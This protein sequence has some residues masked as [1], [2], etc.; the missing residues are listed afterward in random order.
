MAFFDL[1]LE[2]LQTYCSPDAEPADFDAFWRQTLDET[3]RIAVGAEYVRLEDRIY[4]LVDVY[5]VTFRGFGGQAIKGWFLEPAGNDRR[6]PC[7]VTFIGYGGGRSLP[8][9]HLAPVMSGFAHFVVDTRGQGSEWSAGDTADDAG[10]GPHLPG[11]MTRGIESPQTY[12][13]RRL[14]T[15][16]VRAV[17]AAAA[18]RHVDPTRIAVTGSSQGGGLAIAAAGLAGTTVKL[19][20]AD[21]PFLCHFRRAVTMVDTLPYAEIARYLRCHRGRSEQVFRTLDYFDAVN[22]A[23]RVSARSLLSVGL[24]D[25]VCPPSTIYAAYNRIPAPKEMRVYDFNQHEG[26]G[27]AHTVERLRFAIE[28]L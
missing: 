5:D 16:A 4:R 14:I 18:H 28:H 27:A 23:S 15:D 7:V 26:G 21:V 17:Q 3:A 1:P 24:M 11:F 9:D 8:L 19:L 10:A 20:M 2:R 6:L 13:Y 12:Y 25:T 22:F